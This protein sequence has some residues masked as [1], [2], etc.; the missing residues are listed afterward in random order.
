MKTDEGGKVTTATF[1]KLTAAERASHEAKHDRW[2]QTLIAQARNDADPETRDN[3]QL[4]LD[5]RGIS[6][7]LS[8][9]WS[10]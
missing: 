3:A 8:D 4:L 10:R 1:V 6:W 5:N 7:R 2:T 9:E